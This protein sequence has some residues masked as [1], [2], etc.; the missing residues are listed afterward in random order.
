VVRVF[1]GNQDSVKM[2]EGIFDC[3]QPRQRFAFAEAG[4]YKEAGALGFEQRKIAR[5]S[6]RQNGYAQADR[7]P[8]TA[9]STPELAAN[10]KRLSES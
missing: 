8:P 5:T 10:K 2:L 6:G 3:G 1:V 7:F 9:P 4:I